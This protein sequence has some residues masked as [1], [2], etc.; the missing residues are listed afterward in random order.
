MHEIRTESLAAAA[1]AAKLMW[2]CC[3]FQSS[4]GLRLY[5]DACM[6]MSA[7]VVFLYVCNMLAGKST[8]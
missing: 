2:K 6:Y 1:A 4:G 3:D 8:M 7:C 5:E